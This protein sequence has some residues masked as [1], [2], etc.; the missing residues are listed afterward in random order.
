MHQ[1][2]ANS[3]FRVQCGNSTGSGFSYRSDR[4]VI[5]NCHVI[6]PAIGSVYAVP[7]ITVITEDGVKIPAKLIKF[8]PEDE[9]DFAILELQTALPAGRN[10]LQPS[11]TKPSRG[12]KVI[13]AGFPHG[14]H[15]LLVHEAIVS[16]PSQ[17]FGFYL[18]GSV[19]GGN[20]GGPIISAATGELVG[21]VT[22]RRLVGVQDL[23][24]MKLNVK[25]LEVR[26]RE[27][28][29][30]GSSVSIMGIDFS[31]LTHLIGSSLSVVSDL[32]N[33]NANSGIGIGFYISQMDSTYE[34]V[35]LP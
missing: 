4:V 3:T 35:G 9:H 12:S 25:A 18:D 15:E 32:I 7:A 5:T 33:L 28:N 26:A 8:S 20:S 2:L 17:N 30:G 34:T 29:A 24:A 13:F 22:Q 27:M 1:D 10:I 19:N 6:R 11:L 31:E 16:G 14:I 21:I 23:N